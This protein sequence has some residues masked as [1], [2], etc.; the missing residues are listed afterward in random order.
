MREV[1]K[2]VLHEERRPQIRTASDILGPGIAPYC[3]RLEDWSADETL[4]N[5]FWYTEPGAFN[6]PVADRYWMG[7]SLATEAGFGLERA[8]E[9]YGSTTDVAWPR[10]VYVRKFWTPNP[11]T[12]RQWSLW[13]LEDGNPPGLI[14]DYGGSS[15]AQDAY[16]TA[17][18]T[19]AWTAASGWSITR[20][21]TRRVGQNT[22]HIDVE[23][24][25]TGAA[26]TIPASGDASNTLVATLSSSYTLLAGQNALVSGQRGRAAHFN[27]YS[28]R[29][30]SLTSFGGT[31]S[32]GTSEDGSFGGVVPVAAITQPSPVNAAPNGWL[33]CAGA[34]LSRTSYPDLF[35]AIGT[36]WNTGG[37]SGSQFRLPNLPGKVIRA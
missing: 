32:Y 3:V 30:V 33:Y 2:R 14:S 1:E 23:I 18:D 24:L 4:F 16:S 7:Y 13:R 27:L 31:S 36:R 19:D 29:Q 35:G 9:F 25:R 15:V 11:D 21:E 5:G 20:Q 37:E 26:I 8:S 6:Q 10:P 12:P 22:L 28:N 17:N 34:V